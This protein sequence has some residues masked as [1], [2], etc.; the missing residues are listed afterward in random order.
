[1]FAYAFN[2]KTRFSIF[3]WANSKNFHCSKSAIKFQF[4]IY[5]YVIRLKITSSGIADVSKM[6]PIDNSRIPTFRKAE[7]VTAT[8]WLYL[9]DNE[10]LRSIQKLE[11]LA[12][13]AH[14]IIFIQSYPRLRLRG[15]KL[16]CRG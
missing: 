1:M 10:I 7:N 6:E 2:R 14:L 13:Y 4:E 15:R 3:A 11:K 8:S 5:P 16:V 9:N 12:F